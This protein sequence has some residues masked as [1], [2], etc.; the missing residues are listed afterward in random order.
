MESI[1]RAISG[2]SAISLWRQ[3]SRRFPVRASARRNWQRHSW[4]AGAD[5]SLL[6]AIGDPVVLIQAH[7]SGEGKVR[8]D[9]DEHPSPFAVVNVEVVL[10]DP[11]LFQFQMPAVFLLCAD[12]RHNAPWFPCL[13]DANDLVRF[14]GDEVLLDEVITTAFRRIENRSGPFLGPVD[15]PVLKLSCNL[16]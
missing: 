3:E 4:I 11:A 8:T 12:G 13:Q 2:R 6:Q 9:S 5:S 14:G 15:H 10:I 1:G 16:A 7:A